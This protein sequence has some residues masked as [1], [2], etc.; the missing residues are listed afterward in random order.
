MVDLAEIAADAMKGAAAGSIIPG[1]GTAIGAAGA[2]ALDLVPSLGKWLF[3]ADPKKTS[4]TITAVQTAFAGITGSTDEAQQLAAIARDPQAAANLRI[5][6]AKIAAQREEQADAEA[7]SQRQA[8]IDELKTRLADVSDARNQ[9]ITLAKQGSPIA[10]GAPIISAIVLSSF[11]AML[12]V[13][14]TKAIPANQETLANTMLGSL[15]AMAVAV[16]GYWVGSSAGSR[17]KDA[18]MVDL[19]NVA[20]NQ[21]PAD[22]VRAKQVSN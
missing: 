8:Q 7:Q 5:E 16:V 19:A 9:T 14:L 17:T 15:S 6:L 21:V 18:Q 2:V 3:G 20:A 1:A 10:W 13:V 22:L 11:A 12:Y 4:A